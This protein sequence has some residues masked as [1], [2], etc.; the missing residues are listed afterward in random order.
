MLPIRLT[1]PRWLDGQNEYKLSH[2]IACEEFAAIPNQN[3]VKQIQ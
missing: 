2:T 1:L 3:S